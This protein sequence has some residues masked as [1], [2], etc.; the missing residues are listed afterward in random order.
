MRLHQ[1]VV[2]LC[3]TMPVNS[4]A[5]G[6]LRQAVGDLRQVSG[7]IEPAPGVQAGGTGRRFA[8]SQVRPIA[9]ARLDQNLVAAVHGRVD[10]RENT[11]LPSSDE[12]IL[13]LVVQRL[14][15]E[16]HPAQRALGGLAARGAPIDSELR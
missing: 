2:L 7:Q 6:E 8:T 16:P 10:R 3:R 15:A 12:G 13:H 9:Q 1:G 4:L 14:E 11:R 5:Q